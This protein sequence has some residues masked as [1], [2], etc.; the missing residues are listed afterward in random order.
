V[1]AVSELLLEGTARQATALGAPDP[2]C[3]SQTSGHEPNLWWL[4]TGPTVSRPL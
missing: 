1:E 4:I 2:L 3:Q